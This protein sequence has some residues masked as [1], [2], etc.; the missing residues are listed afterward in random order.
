[1]ISI[2]AI[3]AFIGWCSLWNRIRGGLIEVAG[4]RILASI[5]IGLGA[6][7]Y[8]FFLGKTN[9]LLLSGNAALGFYLWAV[10]GWGLYFACATGLWT[11]GETEIGFIDRL[12]LKLFPFITATRHYSN[13]RR[14]IFCMGL[15]GL[16]FSLPMFIGFAYLLSPWAL[17]G[18][19]VMGLQGAVY[20]FYRALSQNTINPIG[21]GEWT[22]GAIGIAFALLLALSA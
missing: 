6:G 17:V 21:Y 15:R 22:W 11:R 2:I 7:A 19:P 3:A 20:Y 16:I 4:G 10:L 13:F 5:M 12:G 9:F 8:A 18:W 1:M 14:G